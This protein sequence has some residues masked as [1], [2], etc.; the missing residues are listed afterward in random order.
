MPTHAVG[1]QGQLF[2]QQAWWLTT[3]PGVALAMTVLGM[4]LLGNGL[5]GRTRGSA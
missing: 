4:N 5:S 2:L 1:Q 3:L